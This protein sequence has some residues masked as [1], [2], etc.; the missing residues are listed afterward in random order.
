[1][2]LILSKRV[3]LIII[4]FKNKSLIIKFLNIIIIKINKINNKIVQSE[5][6]DHADHKWINFLNNSI[7]N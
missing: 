4:L 1:M 2:R 5:M 3:R 7:D 6:P